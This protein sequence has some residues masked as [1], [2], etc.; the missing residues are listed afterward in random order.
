MYVVVLGNVKER[1]HLEDLMSVENNSKINPEEIG[2]EGVDWI[3]IAEDRNK[4]WALV[5]T[6]VDLVFHKICGIFLTNWE[7][8]ILSKRT[9]PHALIQSV[10]QSVTIHVARMIA[11][12]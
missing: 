3:S 9:L 11:V 4:W 6:V 10:N 12:K 5:N 2:W 7:K 8:I 1:G